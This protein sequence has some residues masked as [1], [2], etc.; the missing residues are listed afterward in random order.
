MYIYINNE[1]KCEKEYIYLKINY[2]YIYR[3]YNRV[4]IS[5]NNKNIKKFFSN[6]NC[7]SENIS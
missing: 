7:T 3:I 4:I 5:I 6:K 2:V 1:N